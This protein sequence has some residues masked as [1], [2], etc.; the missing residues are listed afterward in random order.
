MKIVVAEKIAPAALAALKEEAKWTVVGPENINGNLAAE[1]ESA[2]ALIVRSAVFVDGKTL[3]SAKKLRVIGRAGVGVD[4]IDVEAATKRGIAVMNT[5]GANAVA[6]AEHTFALMLALARHLAKADASTRAGKWEKK[7]LQGT[8]LRGKTLGIVGLGRIGVEV[9]KRAKAFG[10]KVVAHDPFVSTVL[11][12]ELG[13]TLAALDEIYRDADYLSLHVGLTPQTQGMIH[14]QTLAKMKK[15]A[16]LVNC[17]RGELIDEAALAAALKSG[18]IAGAA[19]DVFTEEPPKASALLALDN[20]LATPHIAGSTKEAQDAVGVQIAMQVREYLK[21]GVIQNAVNVPSL[22]HEEYVEMQP[23]ISL[24]ERL[25]AFLANVTAGNVEAVSVRYSGRIAEWKTELLRNAAVKGILNQMLAEKAN[26]V[27][28]ASIAAERGVEVT[29]IKKPRTSTGGAGSV[30]SLLIKTNAEEHLAK[31]A[32]LHGK[33]PRLLA[34]D[35]IDIEAPLERDLI[36][37]RN[38]DVPGVIGKVGT[39][40]GRHAINIANFSLG[41]REKNGKPAE[42]IAVVHVDSKPTEAV[43]E[44]LRGIE[45]VKLVKAMRL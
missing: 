28:A 40:L 37:M 5:P 27:N 35:D 19:L 32:V 36:Y 31:G 14:A 38:Q 17:A 39:I 25:G 3:E 15:G 16:R 42:A 6:V 7:A 8:E 11:V 20:V 18:H 44:E 9:A 45:A 10:M 34:V 23:Y 21:R 29:E 12:R 24:A 41:R 30:L 2:D 1:L 4:N 43:L 22:S 26:L 33:S 13:I